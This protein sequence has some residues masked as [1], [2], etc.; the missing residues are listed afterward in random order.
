LITFVVN[1]SIP[2]NPSD[3]TTLLFSKTRLVSL[4][5]K[6]S[7]YV[8]FILDKQKA[9]WFYIFISIDIDE[10]RYQRALLTVNE[11]DVILALVVQSIGPHDSCVGLR[12]L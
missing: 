2:L 12:E 1:E 3:T 11:S 7:D 4:T 10:M 5:Y 9:S 6:Y 8:N